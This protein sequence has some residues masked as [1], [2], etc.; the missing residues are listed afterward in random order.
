MIYIS[1]RITGCKNWREKFLCAETELKAAGFKKIINPLR[2]DNATKSYFVTDLLTYSQYMIIDIMELI[3]CNYIYMLKGWW[4][5]KGA[6][7]EWHIAR[8][9]GIKIIYQK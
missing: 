2:L 7:L 5:S 6:R 9:L 8:R 1:G 4:R 3:N